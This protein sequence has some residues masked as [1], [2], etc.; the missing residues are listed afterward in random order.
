MEL[1]DPRRYRIS[2]DGR[3]GILALTVLSPT[4][5][6]VG[7]YECEVRETGIRVRRER[8]ASE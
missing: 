3:S 4:Q 8:Q 2:N 7:L 5:A 6:D 1:S